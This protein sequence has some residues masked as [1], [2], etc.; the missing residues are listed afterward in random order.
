MYAYEKDL[1]SL[2]ICLLRR[3]IYTNL[4][5][6]YNIIGRLAS[7]EHHLLCCIFD[8]PEGKCFAILNRKNLEI[9]LI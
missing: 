7:S 2:E 9:Y 5:T 6:D 4:Y 8:E 3:K 1:I